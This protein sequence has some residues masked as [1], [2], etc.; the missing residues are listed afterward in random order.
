VQPLSVKRNRAAL[1]PLMTAVV[2]LAVASPV[3]VILSVAVPEVATG[4]WPKSRS[5]GIETTDWVPVPVKLMTI[6]SSGKSLDAVIVNVPV[7]GPTAAGLKVTGRV[8]LPPAGIVPDSAPIEKSVVLDRTAESWAAVIATSPVFWIVRVRVSGV[9]P[10]WRWLLKAIDPA[11]MFRS[12]ATPSPFSVMVGSVPL[13]ASRVTTQLLRAL[14]SIGVKTNDR[15]SLPLDA[16]VRTPFGVIATAP[17]QAVAGTVTM[18][19][20]GP[21]LSATVSGVSATPI[22]WFP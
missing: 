4:T 5:V 16:I 7:F 15:L 9:P 10:L 19:P 18:I 22:C 12:D 13:S 20:P 2:I 21:L 11:V 8:A 14:R 17:P 6:V 1:G 3:L